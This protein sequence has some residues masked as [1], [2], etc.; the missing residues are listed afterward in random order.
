VT[1]SECARIIDDCFLP[2]LN[3]QRCRYSFRMAYVL[4]RLMQ[5]GIVLVV[6]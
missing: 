4:D 1:E 3:G 2:Q 6:P 5:C